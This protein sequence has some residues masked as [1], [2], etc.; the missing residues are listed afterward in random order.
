MNYTEKYHLPQWEETDRVMRT[1]FNQMCADMEAGLR[2]NAQG[3]EEAKQEA[4][5]LPYK[6]GTYTGVDADQDIFLGFRPS[7][8]IIAF[9]NDVTTLS[10][11]GYQ[12]CMMGWQTS[13]K[14]GYFTDTG[15]H[16]CKIIKEDLLVFPRINEPNRFYHYI[17]FP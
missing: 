9:T 2:A 7:I 16:L 12:T 15:L 3:I 10:Y 17:A 8:M 4:K 13:S 5:T 14:T 1:D 6:V 11:A